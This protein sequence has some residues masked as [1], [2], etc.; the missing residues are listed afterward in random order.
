MASEKWGA[1][2]DNYEAVSKSAS[3][4]ALRWAL[5]VNANN[6]KIVEAAGKLFATSSSVA[7]SKSLKLNQAVKIGVQQNTDLAKA[8]STIPSR[9]ADIQ[10][11][12]ADLIIEGVPQPKEKNSRLRVF[13]NCKNLTVDTP[14]DDPSYVGT[15]G[16][17]NHGAGHDHNTKVNFV[18]EIS[19]TIVKL[20][21][22]GL[23][24]AAAPLEVALIAVNPTL[25][26]KDAQNEVLRPERVRIVA[27]T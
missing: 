12:Y 19:Q 20:S 17:F 18:L 7:I 24:Q 9:P 27:V 23:Y 1:I 16:F 25:K 8:L 6:E 3:T 5:G 15:V 13:L 10:E 21:E 14:I 11:A 22:L 26:G 4:N 2:Y